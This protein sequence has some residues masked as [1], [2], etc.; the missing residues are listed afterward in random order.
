MDPRQAYDQWASQ[1]DTNL[2]RTR[3]LEAQ[4]LRETLASIPFNNCLEI[5]CGTGKNTIWL[6]EQAKQVTAVDLSYEM[7]AKARVKVTDPHVQF[8]QADI[9]APWKFRTQLFDLISFSLVLEHIEDLGNIF[10]ESADSLNS[11]GYVYMGELHPG[12]QY[13]GT[14]ARFDTETGRQ[15][16]ECF[17]HHL[18]DF[19]G[20]AHAHGLQL[21]ELN[22][23]FDNNNRTAI[24]RI[25]ILLFQ[26]K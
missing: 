16:V 12:K 9:T 18:S 22:E 7:L 14:K 24:P 6:A 26:K 3:D 1:Y 15:V 5:G 8:V 21:L 23:Y 20:A 2:N 11:G 10:R 25:L 17:T 19:M 13:A 4:A